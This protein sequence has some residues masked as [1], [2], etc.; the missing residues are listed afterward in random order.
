MSTSTK[1][2]EAALSAEI[3]RQ[4]LH[5]DPVTGIFIWIFSGSTA[6]KASAAYLSYT[7][8]KYGDFARPS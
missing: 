2:K 8:K 6:E 5:Y 3:L 7:K 4:K 1:R